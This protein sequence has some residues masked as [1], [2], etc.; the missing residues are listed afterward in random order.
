MRLAVCSRRVQ[1]NV[2][3]EEFLQFSA[4]KINRRR[5]VHSQNDDSCRD[6]MEIHEAQ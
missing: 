5:P 2:K 4:W 3:A 1:A 6:I